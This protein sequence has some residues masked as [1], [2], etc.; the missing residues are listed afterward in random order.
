M[1]YGYEVPKEEETPNQR[2]RIN[3]IEESRAIQEW[4]FKKGFNW[5][6]SIFGSTDTGK[7]DLVGKFLYL[8]Y[9][10]KR[11]YKGTSEANFNK[12]KD[13]EVSVDG[14]TGYTAQGSIFWLRSQAF[15]KKTLNFLVNQN[16]SQRLSR[17]I[18]V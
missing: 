15:L 5:G 13:E 8:K 16:V 3:S 12:H 7:R 9:D 10:T 4:A 11:L 6:T 2:V 14:L 1:F 17:W 18:L